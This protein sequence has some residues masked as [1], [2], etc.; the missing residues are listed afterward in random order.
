MHKSVSAASEDRPYGF[1]RK[2]GVGRILKD[3]PVPFLLRP[4]RE[5]VETISQKIMPAL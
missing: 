4:I 5:P 1:D 3:H 2:V